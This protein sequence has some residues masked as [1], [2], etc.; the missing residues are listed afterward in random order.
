MIM[1]CGG[2]ERMTSKVGDPSVVARTNG[3]EKWKTTVDYSDPGNWV[4]LPE[5][6]EHEVDVVYFYPT[7]FNKTSDGA[8]EVSDI[9]DAGMRR[10]APN[11]YQLQA[12]VFEENCNIYAPYYRQVSAPYSL[13]LS[14][15]ENEELMRYS[16]SQDPAAAL[17]YYFEH[18]NN[19]RPFILAA[20][21]QGAQ[22]VAMLLSDYMKVHPERYENM[23][24]AYVIGYSITEQYLAENPHL[25][26]AQGADDTGVII[27]YNTEGPANKEK[28]NVVVR[29]GAISINPINW[30]R[31][32]TYAPATENLGSLNIAGQLVK[33][34]ADARVDTER[35]VVVCESAKPIIYAIPA[36]A[37]ALFGPE[38]YH[39]FEYSFYYLNLR[40]NAAD[41]IAAFLNYR[42]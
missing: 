25:K 15:E 37:N 35:G 6:T 10:E 5:T 24:A 2:A 42:R 18:Y 8:P 4:N 39:F 29:E 14:T 33:G 41:R 40:Q 16:A 17:D 34:Y 36:P 7:A 21:S 28:A 1:N 19:G 22:I 38:S 31:D 32:D 30:K 13:T 12:T 23:V 27:S 26:F 3:G 9:D 20:H 11:I